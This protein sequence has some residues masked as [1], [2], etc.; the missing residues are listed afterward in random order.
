MKKFM[1]IAV[2]ALVAGALAV[3]GWRVATGRG[4]WSGKGAPAVEQENRPQARPAQTRPPQAIKPEAEKPEPS[5]P[6]SKPPV[7]EK[8]QTKSTAGSDQPIPQISPQALKDAENDPNIVGLI[9]DYVITREDVEK[10]LQ[11]DLRPYD[12]G[13]SST[14][15]EPAKAADVLTKLVA[16]KA[17]TIEARRNGL[18]DTHMIY[19]AVKR[20]K[21]RQLVNLLMQKEIPPRLNVTEAEIQEK[22]KADPKLDRAKAEQAVK[23]TKGRALAS[24]YYDELYKRSNVKKAVAHFPRASEI[25]QRL[26]LR[27]IVERNVNFIRNHQIRDEL[28]DDEKNILMATFDGGKVT[29]LDWFMTIG[30]IAPPY[31]PRDLHTTQGV[32]KLLDRT[33]RSPI[34]VTEAARQGL[35]K[36]E[37]FQKRVREY[38]DRNLLGIGK[39]NKGKEVVEPNAVEIK[40]YFEKD[41]E[42]FVERRKLKVDQIWCADLKSAKEARTQL[43]EGKD[44]AAV[45]QKYST[46]K[47]SKVIDLYPSTE[48]YFWPD[49]WKGEPNDVV[50]PVKGM[51]GNDF[52]WRVVRIVE[53][54]PGTIP[55]FSEKVADR[56]KRV[57]LNGRRLALMDKYNK[58]LLEKYPH[59]IYTDRVKD[60]NPLDIP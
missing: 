36:D 17:I 15:A 33:L 3:G 43:D 24:Q 55:E 10:Q 22:M 20:F 12:Y 48:A 46:D 7:P 11:M 23:M 42:Q 40:S 53:K 27:P 1:A 21:D 51:H 32:D 16:E 19:N 8:P 56:V 39:Q 35:D 57:I 37:A 47:E 31:R 41:P 52:D 29:L 5:K 28:T 26:L 4:L 9:A 54:E 25:H 6:V 34:L 45:K 49:L 13:D 50:G 38:E 58:Q 44:F 30:E 59:K 18:L 14:A 2:F 60:I